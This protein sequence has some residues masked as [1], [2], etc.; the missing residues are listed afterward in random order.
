[1]KLTEARFESAFRPSFSEISRAAPESTASPKKSNLR[2]F[3]QI[4]TLRTMTRRIRRIVAG[5][6]ETRPSAMRARW[7]CISGQSDLSFPNRL[8]TNKIFEE[9]QISVLIS[10]QRIAHSR[11]G[12]IARLFARKLPDTLSL[13]S[14]RLLSKKLWN[15]S[16]SAC[17][18]P[19]Y[20]LNSAPPPC[21]YVLCEQGLGLAANDWSNSDDGRFAGAS[22]FSVLQANRCASLRQIDPATITKKRQV[23]TSN[24]VMAHDSLLGIKVALSDSRNLL[25]LSDNLTL[26][27]T[28]PRR[29]RLL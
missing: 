20:G 4:P 27:L 26:K 9:F 23:P 13:S 7:M 10:V 3:H 14:R 17:F 12:R 25:L 1:L 15:L 21:D 29:P 16:F 18:L 8:K 28:F 24:A 6:A 22:F 5:G 19:F 2:A 11:L